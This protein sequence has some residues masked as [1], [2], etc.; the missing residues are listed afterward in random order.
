[1]QELND[2][3]V[4]RINEFQGK[5]VNMTT[6]FNLYSFDVMGRLAF[7]KDYHMIE[8]GKRHWA[9]GMHFAKTRRNSC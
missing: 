5:P 6:W 3:L 8:N 4:S 9:L 1:M 7:G 2:K